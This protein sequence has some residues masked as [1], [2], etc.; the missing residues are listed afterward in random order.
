MF[1]F[2]DNR[3]T[4][5]EIATMFSNGSLVVDTSYQRRSV[6]SEKTKSA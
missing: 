2:S 5:N 1:N 4:I 3:K 6:W